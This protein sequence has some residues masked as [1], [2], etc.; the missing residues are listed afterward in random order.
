VA[1]EL[2]SVRVVYK[3]RGSLKYST[4][5]VACP[6]AHKS[7]ELS[8]LVP[9]D[10]WWLGTWILDFSYSYSYSVKRYSYSK[11]SN[12]ISL[13]YSPNTW[14]ASLLKKA[15]ELNRIRLFEY[16]H[17][18]R[19]PSL[20]RLKFPTNSFYESHHRIVCSCFRH[21]FWLVP[22]KLNGLVVV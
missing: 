20:D 11:G 8:R 1:S 9:Q 10:L 16:E 5:P 4:S 7:H 15:I 14:G 17:E 19:K 6:F 18:K 12:R 3:H 13:T 2:I 21:F 22:S